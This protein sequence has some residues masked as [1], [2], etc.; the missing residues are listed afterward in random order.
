MGALQFLK[1]RNF[2]F[3][4]NQRDRMKFRNVVHYLIGK[5][6]VIALLIGWFFFQLAFVIN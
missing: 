1:Y 6:I 4:W 2:T 5:G 3:P